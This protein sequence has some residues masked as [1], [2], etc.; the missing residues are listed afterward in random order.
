[1]AFNLVR[2]A[3]GGA[4]DLSVLDPADI[5]IA[6]VHIQV[7]FRLFGIPHIICENPSGRLADHDPGFYDACISCRLNVI[8]IK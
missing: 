3:V 5:R 7:S 2:N 4:F 1:M 6:A 8:V